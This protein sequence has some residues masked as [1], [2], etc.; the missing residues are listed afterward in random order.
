MPASELIGHELD[1]EPTEKKV[2]SVNIIVVIVLSS[3]S[4][5][6]SLIL[7]AAIIRIK[8]QVS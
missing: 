4:G 6:L 3:I 5:V 2:Y 1:D 7:I 8:R